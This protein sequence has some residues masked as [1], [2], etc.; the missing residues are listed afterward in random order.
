MPKPTLVSLD[1]GMVTL[2]LLVGLDLHELLRGTQEEADE[3][4][5][6][7]VASETGT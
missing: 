5:G 6:R 2:E 4:G 7:Q 3:R 1:D